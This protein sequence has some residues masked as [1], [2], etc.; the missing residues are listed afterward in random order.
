[1]RIGVISGSSRPASQSLKISKWVSAALEQD[2]HEI[3]LID[4]HKVD[5][6]LHA[7]LAAGLHKKD[8]PEAWA[9]WQPYEKLL[10]EAD[11]YVIVTPEWNGMAPPALLNFLLYVAAAGKQMAHKPLQIFA[12]SSSRGGA[13]P[14]AELRSFGVK[15]NF[16]VFLPNNIA[17][18]Y[19]EKVFNG[20]QPEEGNNEDAYL[21]KAAHYALKLLPEYAKA[22]KQVRQSGAVD[23]AAYPNGM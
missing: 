8:E 20:P 14:T 19:V 9:A 15:N 5:L 21:Q 16:Y 3:S 17:I 22:L 7:D 4:L 6:P 12:V 1:M 10:S 23:V 13:Y 11:G 18:R 2:G